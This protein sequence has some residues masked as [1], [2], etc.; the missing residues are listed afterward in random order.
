MVIK[1]P[2]TF[3]KTTSLLSLIL[4][5]LIT[6]TSNPHSVLADEVTDEEDPEFY[7]LDETPTILSNATVSSKTRLLV[8]QYKK[9]KKGMRCQVEVTT[10]AME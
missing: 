6:T 2:N 8:S 9:I 4:Y 3:I 5:I 7:I 10:F 1:I